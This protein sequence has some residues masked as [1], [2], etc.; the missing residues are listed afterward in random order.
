M[1]TNVICY[2][3]V[4]LDLLL[5][6]GE[7]ISDPVR[8]EGFPGG[9]SANTAAIL[10]RLG[11]RASMISRLGTDKLSDLLIDS[12]KRGGIDAEYVVRDPACAAPLAVAAID[13]QGNSSYQ[14]YTKDSSFSSIPGDDVMG[15]LFK[16]SSVFH[17][18]SYY[19][20]SDPAFDWTCSLLDTAKKHGLFVTFDPNWRPSKI[21]DTGIAR[22]RINQ[23]LSRTDLLKLSE[24]D[25]LYFSGANSTEDAVSGIRKTFPGHIV[26]TRGAAGASY[27][28]PDSE[29]SMDGIKVR[30]AD[31]IGAGDSFTSALIYSYIRWQESAFRERLEETMKFAITVSAMACQYNGA[32]GGITDISDVTLFTEQISKRSPEKEQQ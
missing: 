1:N 14:F 27:Y 7:K 5:P 12:L 19:S 11:V 29:I 30:V 25:L 17:T 20:Y 6:A 2:G 13:D 16:K 31:T 3:E 32:V 28:G 23:I 9:S 10:S 15:V 24:E 22:K 21:S 26:V 4:L 18:G 8:L